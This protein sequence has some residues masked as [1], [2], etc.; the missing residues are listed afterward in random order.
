MESEK[1]WFEID[2]IVIQGEGKGLGL[3]FDCNVS[4][5]NTSSVLC[6]CLFFGT[7]LLF[8]FCF[9][10]MFSLVFE[11]KTIFVCPSSLIA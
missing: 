2:L 8:F 9:V 11:E 3:T 6:F 10:S 4:I 5:T 7:L 1:S